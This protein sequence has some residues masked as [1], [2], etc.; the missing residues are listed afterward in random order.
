MSHKIEKSKFNFSSYTKMEQNLTMGIAERRER[1]KEQRRNAIVDAAE[2][3]FFSKGVN[4]ATMDDVAEE[5]ELSKGTLY[6][7]FNSKEELY[8]AIHLRGV[9]LLGKFFEEAI[10]KEVTGIEKIYAIGRAYYQF[11]VDYPD[12]FNALIYFEAQSLESINDNTSLAEWT[13]KAHYTLDLVRQALVI[14][15]NDKTIRPDIDPEK[16]AVILWA[17]SSGMIQL[18]SKKGHYLEEKYHFDKTSLIDYAFQ[19]TYQMLRNTR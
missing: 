5:A 19:L 12:Y 9:E 4:V 13:E 8:L 16:T 18:V 15:I 17:Q 14:G 3:V 2:R 11:F 6:L 10:E 1:E 7:Y